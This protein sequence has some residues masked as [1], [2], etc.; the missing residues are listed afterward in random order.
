ML[1]KVCVVPVLES[2]DKVTYLWGIAAVELLVT[3][4]DSIK[5]GH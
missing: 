2:V 4:S 5:L 3:L 1:H